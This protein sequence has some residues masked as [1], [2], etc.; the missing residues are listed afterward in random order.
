MIVN[1]SE[2]VS[3]KLDVECKCINWFKKRIKDAC[4]I[5]MRDHYTP[6]IENWSKLN[7]YLINENKLFFNVSI[8]IQIRLLINTPW[9]TVIHFRKLYKSTQQDA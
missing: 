7:I 4:S 6:S 8:K 2:E 9:F 5:N 1:K 3:S